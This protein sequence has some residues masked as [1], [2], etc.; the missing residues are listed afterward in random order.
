MISSHMELRGGSLQD[1]GPGSSYY[2]YS[3]DMAEQL[4]H[5]HNFDNKS[6]IPG[7]VLHNHQAGCHGYSLHTHTH[8]YDKQLTDV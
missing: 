8:T 2:M 5:V 7:N 4:D 1:P 6:N 3:Q